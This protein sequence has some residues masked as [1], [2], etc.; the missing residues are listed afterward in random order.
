MELE[1]PP[2]RKRRLEEEEEQVVPSFTRL[3]VEG[4]KCLKQLSKNHPDIYQLVGG[5]KTQLPTLANMNAFLSFIRQPPVDNISTGCDVIL[6]LFQ[7]V[8]QIEE[9]ILLDQ[10]V[11]MSQQ[12]Y[13]YLNSLPNEIV[14]VIFE[15]V[16][17][18]LK[19]KSQLEPYLLVNKKLKAITLDTFLR[20]QERFMRGIQGAGVSRMDFCPSLE[21]YY[22]SCINEAFKTKVSKEKYEKSGFFFRFKPVDK[23]TAPERFSPLK[24][25]NL[26]YNFNDLQTLY[27]DYKLNVNPEY[28]S[29]P[30]TQWEGYIRVRDWNL[31]VWKCNCLNFAYSIGRI[32][33]IFLYRKYEKDQYTFQDILERIYYF[34]SSPLTAEDVENLVSRMVEFTKLPEAYFVSTSL[35]DVILDD[36]DSSTGS[37]Q[38]LIND[39][40]SILRIRFLLRGNYDPQYTPEFAQ[41]SDAQFLYRSPN[42]WTR[43]LPK[44]LSD[45]LG[46]FFNQ[47]LEDQL[48]VLCFSSSI[49]GILYP[50]NFLKN[51][52]N[53]LTRGLAL[54]KDFLYRDMKPDRNSRDLF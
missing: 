45:L 47:S 11:V 43:V 46:P 12:E 15:Y 28:F 42:F 51:F 7:R 50:E 44:R 35:R 22:S 21:D 23:L 16:I 37:L 27:N 2:S 3:K 13:D 30:F 39:E 52:K 40:Y 33:Y 25:I 20:E 38:G 41:S 31:V 32:E 1:F 10:P 14:V 53:K 19:Y 48:V 17:K 36:L 6:G 9:Q 49:L 8:E 29:T 4:E 24:E 18:D 5:T 26:D 34:Y 54:R